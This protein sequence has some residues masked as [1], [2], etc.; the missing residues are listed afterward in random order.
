MSETMPS[1]RLFQPSLYID[2]GPEFNDK[3]YLSKCSFLYMS[4]WVIVCNR[5]TSATNRMEATATK[6]C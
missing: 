5:M 1:K 2:D 6:L 3:M 4:K